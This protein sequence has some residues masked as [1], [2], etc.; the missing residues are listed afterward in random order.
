M[1]LNNLDVIVHFGDISHPCSSFRL[2]EG[3]SVIVETW[4]AMESIITAQE[5][6]FK[7]R[8]TIR[9]VLSECEGLVEQLS[10]G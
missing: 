7:V 2:K 6:V 10:E 1:T 9:V 3:E 4:S 5:L 8:H